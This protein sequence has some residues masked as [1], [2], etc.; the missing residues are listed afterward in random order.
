MRLAP[1][2][3]GVLISNVLPCCRGVLD[4]VRNHNLLR[5]VVIYE[6]QD[7]V[8]FRCCDNLPTDLSPTV[9]LTERQLT[10]RTGAKDNLP[11]GLATPV[12]LLAYLSVCL[13][14]YP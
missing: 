11:T 6:E 4:E 2:D 14:I 1:G 8:L 12:G 10:D 7:W 5:L 3:G 13:S 9:Q